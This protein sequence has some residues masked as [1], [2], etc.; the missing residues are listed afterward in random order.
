MI[1]KKKFALI[2]VY[3]KKNLT[4]VCRALDEFN[5]GFI[6]TGSTAKEIIKRGFKCMLVSNLTKFP[7]ILDGRVKTLHPFIHA[8]I[9]HK[10]NKTSHLNT[11][12]KLKLPIID[13]VI[14]NLYPFEKIINVSKNNDKCIEMIDIG[15]PAMLRSAA[16][17]FESVTT[18]SDIYDYNKFIQN[19]QKNKGKTS[20]EF[21]KK[22][23][24]KV[25]LSTSLYDDVISKWFLNNQSK[26]TNH[27][28]KKIRLKYGENPN[29]KSTYLLDSSQHSILKEKIQGKELGYNNIVDLDSGLNCIKEFIEPTC[30]IIKH[31][32]PCGVASKKTIYNAYIKAL[33]ADPV[34]SFGGIVILNRSVNK[35]MATLISKNYFEVIAAPKFDLNAKNILKEKKRLI[36]IKTSKLQI[37]KKK[38]TKIVI[39]GQLNQEKNI[40]KIKKKDL[41]CVSKNK[42][43]T[44]IL[45]DLIFAFKVCKHVTSNAIVLVK[46]KQTIGIGAGQMSRLDSTKIALLKTNK[47]N[48]LN[49]FVAASDAFFPFTDNIKLLIKNNCCSI[50]QPKGSINDKKIIN[51]A[52]KKNISL[53]FTNYRLFKH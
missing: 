50:V 10:R 19:L 42:A 29:Q 20:F 47:K 25:F 21:R 53:Y 37:N 35:K 15:G 7:E 9:L 34:S 44:K 43:S 33:S 48:K 46:N 38:E 26:K 49:K 36:L 40:I 24:K 2:S 45:D 30:V 14:V 22:M 39:G 16:K 4:S 12:K 13:F 41:I 8:S 23:A 28:R 51:F 32:N 5:I 27:N 52:N 17:N 18:I 3:N 31:N 1:N 11:F 6:S